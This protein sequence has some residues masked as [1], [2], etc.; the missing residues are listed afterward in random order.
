VD[1]LVE[2]AVEVRQLAGVV[3]MSMPESS[4]GTSVPSP[5]CTDALTWERLVP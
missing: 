2:A 5:G 1:R 3:W 4:G